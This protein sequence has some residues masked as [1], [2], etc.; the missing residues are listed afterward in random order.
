MQKI[1]KMTVTQAHG[2]SSEV[3]SES[4]LMNTNMTVLL[5]MVF[6][7]LCVLVLWMKV[8]LALEGLKAMIIYLRNSAW[9]PG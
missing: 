1:F 3:L 9:E 4:Y 2:Y 6:Q 5:K 7:N 8:A